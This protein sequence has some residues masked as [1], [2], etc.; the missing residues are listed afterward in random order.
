MFI[1]LHAIL[2]ICG[3][4][5]SFLFN[6]QQN[7]NNK[8][9]VTKIVSDVETSFVDTRTASCLDFSFIIDLLKNNTA[10]VLGRKLCSNKV[11]NSSQTCT[12][13]YEMVEQIFEQMTF[14]PLR[15]DMNIWPIIHSIENNF[16]PPE[17]EDLFT[18]SQHIEQIE[19]L[20]DFM[21]F[22]H[23]KLLLFANITQQLQLPESFL[24]V[25]KNSF[26]DDG[27]LNAEK[28]PTIKKLR[29]NIASLRL[30]IIQTIQLLLKS[31]DMREKLSDT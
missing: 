10:T 13:H 7:H 30:Q 15:T 31:E 16:Q 23:Q 8:H 4:A 29:Q 19:D 26:D 17:Q 28:Y 11:S 3:Y 22:N 12:L 18:F 1:V 6:F 2:I 24:K 21:I 5:H 14:L 9:F 27:N 25:F 20:K